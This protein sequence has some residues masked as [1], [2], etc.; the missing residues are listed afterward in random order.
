MFPLELFN[1]NNGRDFGERTLKF[2]KRWNQPL[3]GS[4]SNEES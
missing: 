3:H 1:P 4:G 2:E